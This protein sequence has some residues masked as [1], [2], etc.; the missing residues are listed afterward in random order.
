MSQGCAVK[1]SCSCIFYAN[2]LRCIY[3]FHGSCIIHSVVFRESYAGFVNVSGNPKPFDCKH[4]ELRL[5]DEMFLG[6]GKTPKRAVSIGDAPGYTQKCW[7]VSN[8]ERKRVEND[9]ENGNCVKD[10]FSEW[11]PNISNGS[12]S[13]QAHFFRVSN[14]AQKIRQRAKYESK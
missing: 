3:H 13:C 8:L 6:H 14:R 10:T 7:S 9:D 5:C 1:Y 11:H 2:Y 4:L 12:L